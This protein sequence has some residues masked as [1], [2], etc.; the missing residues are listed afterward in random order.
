[1]RREPASAAAC[2]CELH[3]L[4]PSPL[5]PPPPCRTASP[6]ATHG[7]AEAHP[8]LVHEAAVPLVV[9]QLIVERRRMVVVQLIWARRRV[10]VLV[11]DAKEATVGFQ[12]YVQVSLVSDSVADQSAVR[13]AL[14][15]T[16]AVI[17][18]GRQHMLNNAHSRITPT[19]FSTPPPSFTSIP[20]LNPIPPTPRLPSSLTC[21]SAFFLCSSDPDPRPASFLSLIPHHPHSALLLR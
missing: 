7:G 16:Q 4:P 1:M 2:A 12:P 13:A 14:R 20:L 9:V 5:H 19:S 17:V 11:R 15:G 10:S 6:P 21:C 18:T 8:G 3:S